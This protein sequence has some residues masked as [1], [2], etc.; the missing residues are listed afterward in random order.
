MNEGSWSTQQENK[1]TT[2]P[3][4]DPVI[5]RTASVARLTRAAM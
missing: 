2:Q 5:V 3:E 1:G 4:K